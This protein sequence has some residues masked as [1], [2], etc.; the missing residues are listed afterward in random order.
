MALVLADFAGTARA[1][2]ETA[3]APARPDV[4][5]RFGIGQTDDL[6]R[7]DTDVRSDI[8]VFGV[9]LNA[10]TDTR[11][12]DGHI[13]S[14]L[15]YRKYAELT[16]DDHEVVGL[17]DG[18][19]DVGIVPQRFDWSFGGNYGQTR[20]DPVS[21][22]ALGNRQR[23][24]V[25]STGPRVTVPV[26]ERNQLELSGRVADR[27]FE[28]TAE[29][30]SRFTLGRLALSHQ[31]DSA[32]NLDVAF[33]SSRNE[34]DNGREPYRYDVLTVAYRRELGSGKMN[35]SL[36]KGRSKVAGTE[37]STSVGS[38]EWSR[39][40]G[41]RSRLSLWTKRDLTDAGELFR[42]GDSIRGGEQS[43]SAGGLTSATSVAGD[44]LISLVVAPVPL[45]RLS[46]GVAVK[47]VGRRTTLDVSAAY[48]KDA[49]KTD[50]TYDNEGRLS[51]IIVSHVLN[52]RWSGSLFLWEFSQDYRS[53]NVH[54]V[55]DLARL[56]FSR[57]IARQL[58]VIVSVQRNSRDG[59][60]RQFD[61]HV[62]RVS[63]VY[64][65]H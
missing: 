54:N 19:L 61:E 18:A 36:G 27:H 47:L 2:E 15:E 24:S 57:S 56:D 63:V 50:E 52:R 3:N 51:Q 30:D 60:F 41:A 39:G 43:D 44:R 25:F 10:S 20:S 14:D 6:F 8:H 7:D 45:T 11:R 26:G 40:I 22:E 35:L 12:L 16:V 64:G 13:L 31:I 1:Q 38:I 9:A 53:L 37:D 28:D 23:T 55:D 42:G 58:R 59:G 4:E 34:F 29:L 49:F 65:L 32:A 48:A 17:L 5:F 33:D 21:P 46:A 62:Y